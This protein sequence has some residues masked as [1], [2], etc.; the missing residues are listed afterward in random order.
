ML[1]V[2]V[3]HWRTSGVLGQLVRFAISGGLASLIYTVVY[4]PFAWYVFGERRAVIAVVPAFFAAAS[5]GYVL[6]SKWS[7]RGHGSR[8]NLRRRQMKFLVVQALGMVLNLAFT[9]VITGPL[10][11]GAA[12]AALIPCFVITPF[13][14]FALNRKLVFG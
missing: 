3:D 14:T 7:F 13:A 10:L 2:R 5:V 6:H 1:I 11:H 9:W 4:L 8:D 12:W